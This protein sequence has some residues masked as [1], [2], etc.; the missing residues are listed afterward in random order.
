MAKAI[1]PSAVEI[2]CASGASEGFAL[3]LQTCCVALKYHC[4][5]EGGVK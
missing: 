1:N 5:K 2:F 4:D 3:I